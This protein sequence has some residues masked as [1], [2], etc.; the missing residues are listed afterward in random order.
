M[1]NYDINWIIPSLRNP[2]LPRFLWNICSSLTVSAVGCLSK[3]FISKCCPFC[4]S[5]ISIAER[6]VQILIVTLIYVF[7]FSEFLNKPKVYNADPLYQALSRRP[8]TVPLIT[9]SNH[10][11]CFDDPGLWGKIGGF[12]LR[13]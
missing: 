10:D 8:L 11:S 6:C 2:V 7:N 9:V 3:L 13:S 4:N 1:V 5:S 12:I